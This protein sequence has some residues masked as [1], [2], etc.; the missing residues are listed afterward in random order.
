[1]TANSADVTGYRFL[2]GSRRGAGVNW[3]ALV[4]MRKTRGLVEAR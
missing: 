4:N 3:G 1:M 2:V